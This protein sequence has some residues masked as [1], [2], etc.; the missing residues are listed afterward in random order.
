MANTNW[1]TCDHIWEPLNKS[2]EDACLAKTICVVCQSIA[3]QME[4]D[5]GD[6]VERYWT[7]QLP[8]RLRRSEERVM[9]EKLKIEP[10]VLLLEALDD[11]LTY[12]EYHA[13]NTPYNE[14]ELRLV[15]Q[16]KAAIAVAEGNDD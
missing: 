13:N 15:E 9:A 4:H 10:L 6:Y 14:H 3:E 1:R 8:L 12:I 11:A 5:A 2:P 7:I 16:I